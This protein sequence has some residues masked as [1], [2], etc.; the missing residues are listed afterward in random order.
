MFNTEFVEPIAQAPDR[1]EEDD[2]NS[3]HIVL[4]V[5]MLVFV[6]L[7]GGMLGFGFC[8]VR[9]EKSG[10]DYVPLQV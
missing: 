2:A 7:V 9:Q 4:I 10:G 6:F 5:L 8:F 1:G 3:H